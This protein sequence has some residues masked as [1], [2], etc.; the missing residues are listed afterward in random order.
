MSAPPPGAPE[1]AAP[2]DALERLLERL[3]P[4]LRPLRQQDR[5]ARHTGRGRWRAEVAL[6]AIVAAVIAIAAT[7]DLTRQVGINYRLTAD[8]ETWR[9]L[10]GHHWKNVSVETD[11]KRFTKHD[12]VCGNVSFGPRSTRKR[13]E[14]RPGSRTQIC[15][16]MVGPIVGGRRATHAGFFVPRHLGDIPRNR[17]GC[18]GTAARQHLC[19]RRPPPGVEPEIPTAFPAG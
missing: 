19:R 11:T 13:E 5:E 12:M 7:Y 18:F 1:H 16:M 2:P 8:I 10:T 9:E 3:P 6:L 17:F 14:G 15:F 4:G